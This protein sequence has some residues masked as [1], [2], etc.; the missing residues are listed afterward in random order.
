MDDGEAH[1]QDRQDSTRQNRGEGQ[2]LPLRQMPEAKPETGQDPSPLDLP[3]MLPPE[4]ISGSGAGE[5][6]NES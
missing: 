4:A 5:D 2:T 6:H 3:Q 1:F